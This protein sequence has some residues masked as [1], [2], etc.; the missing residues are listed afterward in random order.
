[1]TDGATNAP[2][3][4]V[5]WVCRILLQCLAVTITFLPNVLEQGAGTG[6]LQLSDARLQ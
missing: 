2:V 1:M 6:F 4:V 5:S 3:L